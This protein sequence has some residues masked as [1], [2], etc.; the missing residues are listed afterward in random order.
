MN[1]AQ[2]IGIIKPEGNSESDLKT[3][4]RAAAKKYHPDVNP[5]GLEI[6]KL[7][8]AAYDFLKQHMGKWDIHKHADTTGAPSVDEIFADILKKIRHLRGLSIEACGTWLWVTGDTKPNKAALKAAGLRYA[9][10]KQAWYWRPEGYRKK[11]K[12][13]LDLNEIRATFGSQKIDTEDEPRGTRPKYAGN[14]W[15]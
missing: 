3:A 9:P 6:M 10:K 5:D 7:V 14:L 11:S 1:L 15:S 4:Y 2:A 8:N 12:R 13:V